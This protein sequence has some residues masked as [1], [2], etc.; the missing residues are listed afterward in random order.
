M[1]PEY[2]TAQDM[3]RHWASCTH[4][5]GRHRD[6]LR[7]PVPRA[8]RA[9]GHPPPHVDREKRRAEEEAQ[10]RVAAQRR[11]EAAQQQ[12]EAAQRA[13][14]EALGDIL[15]TK[16]AAIPDEY[17]ALMAAADTPTLQGWLKQ[18]LTA[19]SLESVFGPSSAA[20]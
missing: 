18:A 15:L 7:Q 20:P 5:G 13:L 14:S 17:R 19:A 3:L 16:F 10:Q 2:G 12:A 11:T 8:A 6:L 9:A 4:P 1:A